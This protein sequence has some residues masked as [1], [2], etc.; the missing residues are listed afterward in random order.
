M[1][2]L[3]RVESKLFKEM[4]VGINGNKEVICILDDNC[5]RYMVKDLANVRRS[6]KR[7][8]FSNDKKALCF[9]NATKMLNK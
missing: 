6:Y 4:Y 3:L 9:A 2:E 8:E 5:V 7:Y 1:K